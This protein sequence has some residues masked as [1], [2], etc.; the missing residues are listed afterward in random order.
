MNRSL[1]RT[2]SFFTWSPEMLAVP[3]MPYLY[4]MKYVYKALK[5]YYT[6]FLTND[7]ANT[8]VQNLKKKD[9]NRLKRTIYASLYVKVSVYLKCSTN[10]LQLMQVFF[11]LILLQ[12]FVT[13]EREKQGEQENNRQ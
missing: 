13:S 8:Q 1:A 6:I 2:S 12:D 11:L 5:I 9:L 4:N 10:N 7:L 3:D